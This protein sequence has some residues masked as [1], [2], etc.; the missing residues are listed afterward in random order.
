MMPG[1]SGI[2]LLAALSTRFPEVAVVMITALDD[3][4]V[5]DEAFALGA[6]NYLTKPFEANELL[7]ALASTLRRR[8]IDVAHR[9]Q[10]QQLEEMVTDGTDAEAGSGVLVDRAIGVLIVDDHAIFS[11][12]LVRLLRSKARLKVVGTADSVAS[13]VAETIS[14]RPDVVL[15]D[16][17]L[18]DGDG[19]QATEMIKAHLPDT[20]VIM[21]TA[22]TD[23]QSL[24]RAIAAGCTGFVRKADTT[25]CLVGAIVAAYEGDSLTGATDLAPL[26]RQ[27]D[28]THRGL[29]DDL[30]PRELEVLRLMASGLINKQVARH[31][32]L[33][34]NTVRNHSQSILCKLHAHSRLEAV[35][36]AV[37]DGVIAYPSSIGVS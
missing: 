8:D 22:R 1:T 25:D 26:L 11:D 20:H 5:A 13:A 35:A 24:V 4:R 12:S 16:F 31:L 6:L 33:R 37:R 17:E 34:L 19:P 7:I 28:P 21:L 32:G 9:V 23:D 36:N 10:V 27:L 30:T 2:D 29:G 18:P 14:L 15:M 3:P